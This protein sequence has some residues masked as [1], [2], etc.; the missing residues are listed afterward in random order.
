MWKTSLPLAALLLVSTASHAEP[1]EPIRAKIEANI[2]SNGVTGF[3]VSTVDADA[4]APGEVVGTCD[5]GSKKIVYARGQDAAVAPTK[6]PTPAAAATPDKPA[7]PA[8]SAATGAANKPA[9][10][11]D[12]RILT[13]CRD[14]TVSMGGDCKP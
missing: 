6:P 11:P 13:E 12:H 10:T 9:R 1:C 3:T 7:R 2:A 4:V 14:G 8:A 5:N